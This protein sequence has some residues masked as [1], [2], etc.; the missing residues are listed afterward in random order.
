[1]AIT[2]SDAA[3]S[4][5]DKKFRILIAGDL[6]TR[7]NRLALGAVNGRSSLTACTTDSPPVFMWHNMLIAF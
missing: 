6:S 3:I 5:V 1:M 4:A 7:I 2:L